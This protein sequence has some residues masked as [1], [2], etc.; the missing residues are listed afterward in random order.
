MRACPIYSWR[1]YRVVVMPVRIGHTPGLI[2]VTI[3]SAQGGALF[4][5]LTNTK[6]NG[7]RRPHHKR[8][9]RVSFLLFC[10][11]VYLFFA[12]LA[13]PLLFVLVSSRSVVSSLFLLRLVSLQWKLFARALLS[14]SVAPARSAPARTRPALLAARLLAAL[15][16][17]TGRRLRALSP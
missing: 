4:A 13:R 15:V 6:C 12:R 1:R 7:F 3:S 8:F 16:S 14:S 11:F 17:P 5:A 10:N 9:S 2:K